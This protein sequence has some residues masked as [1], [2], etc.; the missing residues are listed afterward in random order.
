MVDTTIIA[1]VQPQGDLLWSIWLRFDAVQ[2]VLQGRD[3][4]PTAVVVGD[5]TALDQRD[6]RHQCLN[7][8]CV[9]SCIAQAK[10]RGISSN[11]TYQ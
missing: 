6:R 1:T 4:D 7:G 2:S 8:V 3:Q 5:L 11:L 10:E 9:V